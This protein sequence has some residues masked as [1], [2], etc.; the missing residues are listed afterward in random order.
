MVCSRL[1][2]PAP[3]LTTFFKGNSFQEY[4]HQYSR[5]Q[6]PRSMATTPSGPSPIEPAPRQQPRDN[7]PPSHRSQLATSEPLC[8]VAQNM[9]NMV[10]YLWFGRRGSPQ[11]T[12]S[13]Y[14]ESAN[15]QFSPRPEFVS[16]I[17]DLLATTQ[18]SQSVITLAL[19]YIY[20]LKRINPSIRGRR[21]SEYRLAVT[22]LMLANKFLDE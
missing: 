6:R 11:R 3:M 15:V 16:F 5:D 14:S 19:H 8:S 18:V 1:S 17:A 10:C 13:P 7:K 4:A 2:A 9:C 22:A 20:T 12:S 21:G